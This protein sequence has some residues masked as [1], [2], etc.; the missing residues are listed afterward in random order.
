[1]QHSQFIKNACVMDNM[2]HLRDL[3]RYDVRHLISAEEQI[4]EAM[5]AMIGKATNPALKQAL[6]QHLR[7]TEL[8]RDRLRQVQQHLGMT[9]SNDDDN[10]IFAGLFGSSSKNLGMDGLIEEGQKVMAVDMDPAVMDAAIIGCAQKIE[11]Y[12]IACY[13]TARTYAAQLGLN[14]VAQLLEQTLEEERTSDELLTS[15]AV[16]DVNLRA[17]GGLGTNR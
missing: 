16:S 5:P 14:D 17:E 11:H 1:M 15:L 12:E 4:I 3:L 10:S 7:V 6:E 9:D 2:N 13:G 8:Q